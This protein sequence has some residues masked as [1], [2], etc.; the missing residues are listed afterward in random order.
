V[1]P[2]WAELKQRYA[3]RVEFGWKIAQMSPEACPVSRNQEVWFDRRS[4]T[5]MRSPY[6]LNPAPPHA[7][8]IEYSALQSRKKSGRIM[9]LS[10]PALR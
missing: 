8:T 10:H 5:I 4:G 9:P 3:G 2:A 6:A 1:E 7:H